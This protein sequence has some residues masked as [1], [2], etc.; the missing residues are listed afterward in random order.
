MA[1]PALPEH[2]TP[3]PQCPDSIFARILHRVYDEVPDEK[4]PIRLC[5]RKLLYGDCLFDLLKAA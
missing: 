5:F 2:M 4:R 1:V 3:L